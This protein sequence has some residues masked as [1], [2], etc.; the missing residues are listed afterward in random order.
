MEFNTLS[1]IVR[2]TWLI[3]RPYVEQH[4]P[5]IFGILA[6][7]LNGAELFK[8]QAEYEEPFV[9]NNGQRFWAYK[10]VYNRDLGRFEQVLLEDTWPDNS[11]GVIPTIGP[12]I[13]YNGGCG[14]TGMVQRQNWANDFA[15][16]K[17][18]G[19]IMSFIDGPGGQADGTP[20]YTDFIAGI[21]KPTVAFVDG[22]A[23]SADAWIAAGHDQILLANNYTGFGS[24]GCYC[25]F[26]DFTGYYKKMGLK[27]KD[28]YSKLSP[29][30]NDY[31]RKAQKGD[32]SGYEQIADECA[33]NFI[34]QFATLRGARLKGS[35]WNKGGTFNAKESLAMGLIDGISSFKDA[36]VVSKR[37]M[38][39]KTS[40][41][42]NQDSDMKFAYLSSFAGIT[43]VTDEQ[44]DKANAELTTEG[45]TTVTLVHESFIQEAADVTTQNGELTT[46]LA[47]EKTAHDKTKSDLAALNEDKANIDSIKTELETTK[48]ELTTTKELLEKSNNE[49][50]E[51]KEKVAA[52]GK[53]A[54]GL[55]KPGAGADKQPDEDATDIQAL[56]DSMP[57]NQKADRIIG[58]QAS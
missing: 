44:L 27:V 51:L 9:V 48:T 13:K 33:G 38:I 3:H 37:S 35:E 58:K 57:H 11:V 20:Q 21:D 54:G 12:V 28:I 25:T 47:E 56:I 29:E 52:F 39:T 7:K 49:I 1:A 26:A 46:Q 42:Q 30:K 45:I 2:G 15:K 19:K 18:I 22:G 14:E 43:K 24:I 16:S 55:H 23:Y 4:L 40:S 10:T 53:N 6:G 34:D 41:A 31:Y 50:T 5:I 32:F 17:K 36:A 8:G